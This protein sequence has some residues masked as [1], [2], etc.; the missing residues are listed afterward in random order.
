MSVD[1]TDTPT[2][3]DFVEAYEAYEG[4]DVGW[5]IQSWQAILAGRDTRCPE[6]RDGL[7]QVTHGSCDMCGEKNRN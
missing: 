2:L 6:T 1:T 7:H 4:N 3:F 5:F